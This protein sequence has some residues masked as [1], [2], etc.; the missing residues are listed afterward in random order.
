MVEWFSCSSDNGLVTFSGK[1]Q[2]FASFWW[3]ITTREHVLFCPTKIRSDTWLWKYRSCMPPTISMFWR[4][5]CQRTNDWLFAYLHFL[6][7]C[8]IIIPFHL[9]VIYQQKSAKVVVCSIEKIATERMCSFHWGR[10]TH[11][12][13]QLRW[14]A[15]WWEGSRKWS[16]WGNYLSKYACR[17][18]LYIYIYVCV[19]VCFWKIVLINAYVFFVG[20]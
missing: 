11:S 17:C 8:C 20:L 18:I 3:H 13:L 4:G 7:A 12:A 2:W 16:G 15:E 10:V 5:R 19:C 9:W 1:Y 14:G 6:F